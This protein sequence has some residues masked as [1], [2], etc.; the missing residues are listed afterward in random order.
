MSYMN[1]YI[2]T[3]SIC[4]FI[5][6]V[7]A[8]HDSDNH[9]EKTFEYNAQYKNYIKIKFNARTEESFK[10]YLLKTFQSYQEITKDFTRPEE[11]LKLFINDNFKLI[12]N[13]LKRIS[14]YY[15][16]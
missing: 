12:H 1:N 7:V 3:L 15:F 6:P 13:C 11:D 8:K 9:I 5:A 2:T 10:N 14:K 4:E 16:T